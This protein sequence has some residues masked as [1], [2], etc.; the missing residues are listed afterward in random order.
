MV[1]YKR[2]A[3]INKITLFPL[4]YY[5]LEAILGAILKKMTLQLKR[6]T[7][8]HPGDESGPFVQWLVADVSL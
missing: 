7:D 1:Y 8:I 3:K 2:K 4:Y 5:T 6:E